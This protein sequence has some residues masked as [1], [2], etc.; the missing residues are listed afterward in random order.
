MKKLP[1]NK[2]VNF[3]KVIAKAL[4]INLPNENTSQ[5]Y[6]YFIANNIDNFHKNKNKKSSN[7]VNDYELDYYGTIIS[8]TSY[9]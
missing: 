9:Y 8:R 3:A 6:Y 2:Q 7:E 1:S 4:H 5:A